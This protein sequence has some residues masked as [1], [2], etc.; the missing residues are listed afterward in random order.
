MF[1]LLR[2]RRRGNRITLLLVC[3]A[4][5][6]EN[7]VSIDFDNGYFGPQLPTVKPLDHQLNLNH[8]IACRVFTSPPLLILSSLAVRSEKYYRYRRVVLLRFLAHLLSFSSTSTLFQRRALS[9]LAQHSSTRLTFSW[10]PSNS[11][12][13]LPWVPVVPLT[14][15]N[16]KS[17]L[18]RSRFLK[19]H[20]NSCIHNVALFPTVVN[21]AGWKWVNPSVGRSRY[22]WAKV[23]RREIVT[24][25]FGR[26]RSRACRRNIRSALLV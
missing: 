13:K 23:D 17:F 5:R 26:R 7:D 21:W 18:A 6:P 8:N 4:S 3:L 11:V 24:A 12:K 10:S 19:S 25:N 2:G 9:P 16:P 1:V 15:L 22:F 14:P 20:N